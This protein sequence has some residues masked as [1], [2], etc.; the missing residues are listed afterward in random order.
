MHEDSAPLKF[1]VRRSP[2]FFADDADEQ[3]KIVKIIVANGKMMVCRIEKAPNGCSYLHATAVEDPIAEEGDSHRYSRI[4]LLRLKGSLSLISSPSDVLDTDLSALEV[5]SSPLL[6]AWAAYH[7]IATM[8]RKRLLTQRAAH[9]LVFSDYQ[10]QNKGFSVRIHNWENIE[11]YK[12]WTDR[13]ERLCH[14]AEKDNKADC[15]DA[16]VRVS[17]TDTNSSLILKGYLDEIKPDGTAILTIEDNKSPPENGKIEA[18]DYGDRQNERRSSASRKLQTGNVGLPTLLDIMN[19]PESATSAHCKHLDSGKSRFNSSQLAAIEHALGN[20]NIVLIQGPPGTGKTYVI[21][22]IVKRL[23]SRQG[24]DKPIRLLMSSTQNDAVQ[25]V[26]DKLAQRGII[27]HMIRSRAALKR[28]KAEDNYLYLSGQVGDMCTGLDNRLNEVPELRRT[29][30]TVE[31]FNQMAQLLTGWPEEAHSVKSQIGKLLDK[32]PPVAKEFLSSRIIE[33]RSLLER[34]PEQGAEDLSHKKSSAAVLIERLLQIFESND[35]RTLDLAQIK[36]AEEEERQLEDVGF[37]HIAEEVSE[38]YKTLRRARRDSNP[39]FPLEL[40]SL[41]NELK[42]AVASVRQPAGMPLS[43]KWLTDV[44]NWRLATQA[45]VEEQLATLTG[46]KAGILYTWKTALAGDPQLWSALQERYAQVV[47]ATCQMAAP[48]ER[49]ETHDFYDYVIIDEAARTEVFDLLIPMVQ[50]K[51]IILVGDQKQLPP[52]VDQMIV[53]RLEEEHVLLDSMLFEKETLFKELFERLPESNRFML[54]IQYRSNPVIGKAISRAFYDDKLFSGAIINEG[55]AYESWLGDKKPIWGIYGDRPLVWLDSS[56][57]SKG[58]CNHVNTEETKL[59]LDLIKQFVDAE[60]SHPHKQK[61]VHFI[62]V[63][64]YYGA[65]VE[66]LEMK[67]RVFP[68]LWRHVSC[69]TVD[70]FQGKEFPVVIICCSRHDTQRGSVGFLASPNRINVAVSRAQRQL[71]VVGSLPTLCH[72]DT[73]SGSLPFKKF[74]EAAGDTM[75][76]TNPGEGKD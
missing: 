9:A 23:L 27:I 50:G 57:V 3:S 5:R 17:G 13:D 55:P 37:P 28:A 63:I 14:Q 70:S 2:V 51:C 43:E 36:L 8:E 64:A 20:R 54:N 32:C 75:F 58:F 41:C 18:F 45:M 4:H 56:K 19:A 40:K 59:V 38:A 22:E 74:V 30:E 60:T 69:G 53:R 7:R 44:S 61:E 68:S 35:W 48:F 42:Q 71:I 24:K 25:N 72:R 66:D 47:G 39:S 11:V 62:G 1:L 76:I 46:T 31:Q 33:A 15:I 73:N 6:D 65:Q 12:A 34:F 10:Q 26:I 16:D 52:M 29:M 21:A 49:A 67:I